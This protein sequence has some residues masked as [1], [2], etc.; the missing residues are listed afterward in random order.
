MKSI[1]KIIF[2][3]LLL[4]FVISSV[5]AQN[6]RGPST[7][8]ERMTAVK[9]AQLLE[10]EPFHKEAKKSASGLRCV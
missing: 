2:T 5:I 4:I 9:A 3:C 7:P 8:E 10:S 1:T 6:K